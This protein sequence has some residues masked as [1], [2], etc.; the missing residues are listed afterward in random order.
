M[1]ARCRATMGGFR[2]AAMLVALAFAQ[3]S[4]ANEDCEVPEAD[5]NITCGAVMVRFSTLPF[6]MTRVTLGL[7]H[8]A[9]CVQDAF[10]QRKWLSMP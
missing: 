5:L 8:T 9:S 10:P 1:G 6:S 2:A 3:L 4:N 7:H